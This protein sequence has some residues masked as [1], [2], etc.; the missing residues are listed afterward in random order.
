M[1]ARNATL[2]SIANRIPDT[3]EVF[4]RLKHAILLSVCDL[5]NGYWNVGLDEQSKRL[6]AFGSE[7]SQWVWKCLPQGM[8]MVVN[9]CWPTYVCTSMH[10]W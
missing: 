6:T 8:V 1:Q 4:Q 10:V 7:Q 3:T 9:F 5:S 2:L